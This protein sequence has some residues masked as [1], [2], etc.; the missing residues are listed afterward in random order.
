MSGHARRVMPFP[1]TCEY[2]GMESREALKASY[3][4]DK[5]K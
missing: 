5:I 1:L 4:K 3:K 2:C